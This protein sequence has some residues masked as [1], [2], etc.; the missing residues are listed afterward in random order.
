[1]DTP[2]HDVTRLPG[3]WKGGDHAAL[4]AL[5]PLVEA[6]LRRLAGGY[7]RNERSGH[8]LQPTALDSHIFGSSR[9]GAKTLLPVTDE[10]SCDQAGFVCGRPPGG[11][12]F[13][14]EPSPGEFRAD[15][16]QVTRIP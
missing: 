10:V 4:D 6:Q 14:G 7:M 9:P 11:S 3:E 15:W 8:T 2:H 13:G 12:A 5:M 1:M 16:I